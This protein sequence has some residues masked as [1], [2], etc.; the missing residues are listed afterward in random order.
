ML[1]DV[2][3]LNTSFASRNGLNGIA[4]LPSHPANALAPASPT[5]LAWKYAKP[6]PKQNRPNAVGGRYLRSALRRQVLPGTAEENSA[7]GTSVGRSPTGGLARPP[8]NGARHT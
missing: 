2:L 8:R 3:S 6:P 1:K 4:R 5:P 7:E